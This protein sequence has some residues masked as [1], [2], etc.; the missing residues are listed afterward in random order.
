MLLLTLFYISFPEILAYPS[1]AGHCNK[2]SISNQSGYIGPHGSQGGGALSIGQYVVKVDGEEISNV[3]TTEL[4]VGQEYTFTLE[5]T[6]SND[7]KGFFFRLADL[8]DR[9]DTSGAFTVSSSN[10]QNH[11]LCN[12]KPVSGVTHT[13]RTNKR[14]VEFKVLLDKPVSNIRL[15]VTVVRTS[16]FGNWFYSMFNLSAVGS[17]T[18]SPSNIP[19][20]SPS[21]IPSTSPSSIPSPVPLAKFC[22]DSPLGMYH[23]KKKRFCKKYLSTNTEVKCNQF[24]VPT[25]CPFSCK[26]FFPENCVTAVN[27]GKKF[28]TR[29]G[30]EVSCQWVKAKRWRR[31]NKVFGISKTCRKICLQY[32]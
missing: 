11:P 29:K 10:I 4:N 2:G 6:G 30:A 22:V 16:T 13:G 18:P 3:E 14:K 32:L 27:T 24:K 19:S 17:S 28:Y 20:T 23:R 21:S 31:C 7:F 5:A 1:Y 12:N 8:F 25:H 26:E 9:V 15:D